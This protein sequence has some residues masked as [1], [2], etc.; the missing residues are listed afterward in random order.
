M[1]DTKGEPG[2]TYRKSTMGLEIIR[3]YVA[4]RDSFRKGD[5]NLVS[6]LGS[7]RGDDA[8]IWEAK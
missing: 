6:V 3:P 7:E 1:V 5:A 2:N 8:R 4:T